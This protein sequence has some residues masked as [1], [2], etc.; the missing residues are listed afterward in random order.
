MLQS[1]FRRSCTTNAEYGVKADL[2][3]LNPGGELLAVAMIESAEA[4]KNIDQILSVPGLGGILIGPSDM[5]MDMG[6]GKGP[7]LADPAAPEVEAEPAPATS[8]SQRRTARSARRGGCATFGVLR[9]R[10]RARPGTAMKDGNSKGRANST[11]RSAS[12]RT[13]FRI[14]MR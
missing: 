3:P 6:V 2:W 5:S 1:S 4:I 7:G 11:L 13:G 9:T 14:S 12:I 10:S 8:N